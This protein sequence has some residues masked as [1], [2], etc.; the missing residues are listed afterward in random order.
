MFISISVAII[1]CICPGQ[2]ACI[3]ADAERDQSLVSR[4]T[5]TASPDYALPN[6]PEVL[7]FASEIFEIHDYV[8]HA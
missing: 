8:D 4:I 1:H 5:E 2:Y 7:Q 6:S 3:F